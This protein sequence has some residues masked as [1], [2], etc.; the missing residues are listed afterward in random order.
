MFNGRGPGYP[1]LGFLVQTPW[2]KSQFL[3]VDENGD[4][5]VQEVGDPLLLPRRFGRRA[6]VSRRLAGRL[7]SRPGFVQAGFNRDPAGRTWNCGS[8]PSRVGIASVPRSMT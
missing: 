8:C 4:G 2:V 3:W 5:L 6:A 7:W 1:Y